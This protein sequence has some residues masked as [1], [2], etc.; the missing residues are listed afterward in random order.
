MNRVG[1]RELRQNASAVLRRVQDGQSVE[2][3]VRGQ[4]VALLVPIPEP[5]NIVERLIAEGK[6]RPA[7]GDLLDLPP[8]I[9][10]REGQPLLSEVLAEMR[11]EER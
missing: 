10:L 3:T 2:V 9:R 7:R 6:A 11:D 1:V 8:P 4:P 5:D